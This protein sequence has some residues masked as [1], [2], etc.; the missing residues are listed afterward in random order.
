MSE[1]KLD[2]ILKQ[3]E[4]MNARVTAVDEFLRKESFAI[5][6]SPRPGVCPMCGQKIK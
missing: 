3:L 5:N 2:L 4:E 1:D 6:L